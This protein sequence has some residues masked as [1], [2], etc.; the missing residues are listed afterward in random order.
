MGYCPW[1]HRELDMTEATAHACT[2]TFF[3]DE[4]LRRSLP[5]TLEDS[6]PRA[7]SNWPHQQNSNQLAVRGWELLFWVSPTPPSLFPKF[8]DHDSLLLKIKISA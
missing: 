2:H 7:G 1:G 8:E 5:R 3:Q 6:P 4:T